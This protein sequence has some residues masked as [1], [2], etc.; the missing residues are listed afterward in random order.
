MLLKVVLGQDE[1][2]WFLVFN[3][4]DFGA[5]PVNVIVG[6]PLVGGRADHETISV[7]VLDLTIDTEVL[8]AASVV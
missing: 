5:P 3:F 7:L 1:D 8:I 6:R 4:L 2:D